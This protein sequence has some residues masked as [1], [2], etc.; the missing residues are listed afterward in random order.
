MR[1]LV[2]LFFVLI[3][4]G[5]FIIAE[6]NLSVKDSDDR[7]EFLSYYKYWLVNIVNNTR[8]ILGYAI[9]MNWLP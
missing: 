9:K 4:A 5:L 1:I 3:L 7:K 2:F 6:K 8:S